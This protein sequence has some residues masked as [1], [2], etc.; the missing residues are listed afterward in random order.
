MA[1]TTVKITPAQRRYLQDLATGQRRDNRSNPKAEHMIEAGLLAW[2]P[3]G[4]SGYKLEITAKGRE[5]V[6]SWA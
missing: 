2:Q 4:S 3:W 6:S 5:L 1:A